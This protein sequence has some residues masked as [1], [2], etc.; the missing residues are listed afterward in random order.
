MAD[1]RKRVLVT[2][3]ATGIGA[4]IVRACR[5]EG[6]SV[7]ATDVD[8]DGLESL[9]AVLPGLETAHLDVSDLEGW[10]RVVREG[11]AAGGPIDVLINN[12]GV[13]SP[14]RSDRVSASDDRRTVEVNL[15]GV[16]HGVRTILPRFL[17]RESGH[18]IN[19]ASMAAFAPAPDLAAYC[20]TKHAVRA[21]THSCAIDHRHSAIHWTLACPSAV[22]TPMLQSM[23]EK[24]AGVV[25]FTETPMPPEAFAKE[26]IAVIH[27]PRRELLVP[28]LRGK[29]I[30]F[31]GLFPG[32]IARGMDGAEQRGRAALDRTD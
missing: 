32:L 29:L 19:I 25:V 16:L 27:K 7:V 6:F 21:Y 11:E 30:R 1:Q 28:A 24:R 20:A 5:A 2:G 26:I 18:V 12:A 14:G 8:V 31:F 15:M 3:G 4:A 22:E 10:E 13:C 9:R 17:E 23:R